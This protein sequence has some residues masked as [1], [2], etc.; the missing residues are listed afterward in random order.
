MALKPDDYQITI[1]RN[2]NNQ[3]AE[4]E[5]WLRADWAWEHAKRYE[6][7]AE[8]PATDRPSTRLFLRQ[9]SYYKGT[10]NGILEAIA[11]V[12]GGIRAHAQ[13]DVDEAWQ[14]RKELM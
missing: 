1:V 12:R 6:K 4:D 13:L 10:L 14:R 5:L 11:I 8:D 7:R 2:N 3:E 9:Y